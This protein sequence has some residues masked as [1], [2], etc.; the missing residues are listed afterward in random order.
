MSA[1]TVETP[2]T[3]EKKTEKVPLAERANGMLPG[4]AARVWRYA[5]NIPAREGHPGLGFRGFEDF[6]KAKLH[7]SIELERNPE[8]R[9]SFF[10]TFRAPEGQTVGRP[11]S[12][13]SLPEVTGGNDKQKFEA[14]RVE[15]V[16]GEESRTMLG[17][18]EGGWHEVEGIY[19]TESHAT[20]KPDAQ[21]F[22]EQCV[23]ALQS[24]NAQLFYSARPSDLGSKV[25]HLA[26]KQ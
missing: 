20:K 15:I 6:S 24:P 7:G 5:T 8:R 1:A 22:A 19:G 16:P 10:V 3:T 18:R 23:G 2:K 12:H 9:N 17:L 25:I 4:F 11:I 14:L 21:L 13:K 26:S